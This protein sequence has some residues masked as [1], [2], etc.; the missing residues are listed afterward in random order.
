MFLAWAAQAQARNA[1]LFVA[2]RASCCVCLSIAHVMLHLPTT[3]LRDPSPE[4]ADANV[5]LNE[6]VSSACFSLGLLS[7]KPENQTAISKEG[8]NV[9]CESR[10]PCNGLA[11]SALP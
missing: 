9:A 7:A 6:I 3:G 8:A 5:W 1:H 4:E 2:A 11:S 10:Q